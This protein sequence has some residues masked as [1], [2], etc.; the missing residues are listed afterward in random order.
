[1]M[2]YIYS[3]YI[4]IYLFIQINAEYCPNLC[5]QNGICGDMGICSCYDGWT[6]PSC[7]LAVC[8][9]GLAWSDNVI[10]TDNGHNLAI[11]S[12]RGA[13]DLVT[14]E[15]AC[16]PGFEGE[17]CERLTCEC[18]GHGE[19]LSMRRFAETKDPGLGTVYS[20]TNNWDS[21]KIFGCKCDEGF[22]GYDCKE[23]VC[24][25][26]DDPKTGDGTSTDN[27][28]QFNEKQFFKCAATS[29]SFTIAFRG[30][31]T[32]AIYYDDTQ[33][34]VEAKLEKLTTIRDVS[35]SFSGNVCTQTGSTV[36]NIEFLTEYGDLPNIVLDATNLLHTTSGDE[37]L[38]LIVESTVTGTKENA[39][40]SNRGLCQVTTGLCECYLGFGS[41]GSRGDCGNEIVTVSA[42]PGE[43][44]SCSGH[45]TCQG[46]TKGYACLC[47]SGWRGGDCN[48][49]SC[50]SGKSWF[51]IPINE[52]DNAHQDA[53]CSNAGT[54]DRSVGECTCRAGFTGDNCNR[55]SC[56]N[57]C[58][59]HGACNTMETLAAETLDNGDATTWT[60]G[61]SFTKE[62]WDKDMIQGCK[63][64]IG[65]TGHD[66]SLRTCPT[67]DDP[68]TTGQYHEVQLIT[69]TSTSTFTLT[70]RQATTTSIAYSASTAT[71][72]SALE[73]LSTIGD[74][75]VT[76]SVNTSGACENNNVISIK[77]M[78]NFGSLPSLIGAVD[79]GTISITAD[80]SGNSIKGTKEDAECSNR[81][82]CNTGT[83]ICECFVG[84]TSS[85]GN[86][87][88]G[89]RGDCGYK[90]LNYWGSAAQL[91]N[92]GGN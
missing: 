87:N 10:G 43:S 17:A 63:C 90:E 2:N 86:G 81:G 84:F 85:D 40:C 83:G 21:D 60:Y 25:T 49:K 31:T 53:E 26:G 29:G 12:N 1:M 19:C 20:Y 71:L 35:V 62:T 47:S 64:D 56:P 5:S 67:G 92:I 50:P 16:D 55:M 24:P 91:A 27:P 79:S 46:S 8:P 65:Y 78:D 72:E 41:S 48:E 82:I 76:Y 42:C 44:E 45:G 3:L 36:V 69:C 58:S 9:E 38:E 57:E 59:G 33:T 4:I 34:D 18:N 14:G 15:C 52:D 37:S 73:D 39:P 6:G 28:V 61:Q 13:C 68:L 80:G 88:A 32:E 23:R 7:S 30:K 54:C 51:D 89:N 22:T 11:C 74:V 77:F 66:C 70:F 75:T